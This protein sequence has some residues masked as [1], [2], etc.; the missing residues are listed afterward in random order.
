MITAG[1]YKHYKNKF[2]RVIGVAKHSETLED[3]VIYQA[4]YN[5][6]DF[7]EKSFW[8]RPLVNFTEEV[9]I[10]NETIPRFT[11]IEEKMNG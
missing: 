8:I 7:G 2:Y 1:I 6:S 10:E 11:K 5:D 4:L 3:F 9:T